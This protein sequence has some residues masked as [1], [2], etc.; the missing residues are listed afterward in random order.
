LRPR[1]F[2]APA[3][4]FL[5]ASCGY[6]GDPLPPLAN[7]PVT[8]KDLAAIQRGGRIIAHFTIPQLTT[9]EKP[10]PPPLT[11]DLRV[12]PHSGDRFDENEWAS[13]SRHVP[14]PE[15]S[16]GLATY[17]IPAA[18]W[19]GKEVL[20]AVR[21]TAGNG[22]QSNWSN[23]VVVPVIAPPEVPVVTAQPTAQG[24]RLSWNTSGKSFRIVRKLEAGEYGAAATVDKPEWLDAGVEFGKRYS[25]EVQALVALDG[26]RQAEGDF[27][28]EVSLTPLD[29]FAPA[30]PAGL[31]G[32]AAPSSVELAWDRNTEPDLAGYR[33]Y[34]AVGDGAMERVAEIQQIP[35]WSDRAVE[36]GK[37]YRY[38]VT[39][40]DHTGNESPRAPIIAVAQP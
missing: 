10:I 36:S 17:E 25:Y 14:A 11:L 29:T 19:R 35:S 27:S 8:V 1:I 31:H 37:T 21:I 18:E 22:K 30:T 6:I 2:A 38:T 23:I 5:L 32:E 15:L 28:K 13:Q 20:I 40:F 16:D 7:V 24:V 4:A 33:V 9:E 3:A 12:G 34:R 26:G 39:A